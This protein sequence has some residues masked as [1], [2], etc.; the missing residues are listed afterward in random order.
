[1]DIVRVGTRP[2]RLIVLVIVQ[3]DPFY[4]HSYGTKTVT[5]SVCIVR[6][7]VEVFPDRYNQA[8]AHSCSALIF[9]G[10]IAV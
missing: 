1:M 7:L 9:D 6:R 4:V 2:A 5:S 8:E 3:L 10:G